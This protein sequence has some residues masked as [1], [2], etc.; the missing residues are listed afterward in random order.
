MEKKHRKNWNGFDKK[1]V[2]LLRTF[3]ALSRLTTKIMI[4]QLSQLRSSLHCMKRLIL[5]ST[6]QYIPHC[7]WDYF[8][9]TDLVHTV[10]RYARCTVF[11][12]R[13]S[14]V[15]SCNTVFWGILYSDLDWYVSQQSETRR[16]QVQNL[17]NG[18]H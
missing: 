15:K 5:H 17:K 10:Y 1:T 9:L 14:Y 4:L 11:M 2:E 13:W 3:P 12:Y 6:S 7:P 18:I 8:S 16:I